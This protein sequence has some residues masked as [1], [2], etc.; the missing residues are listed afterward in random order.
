[1]K[2]LF[3]CP[4]P[5]NHVIVVEAANTEAAVSK[6]LIAGALHCRNVRYQCRCEKAQ[7]QTTPIPEEKL[8]QIVKICLTEV[9]KSVADKDSQPVYSYG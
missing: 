9:H 3:A 6:L 2:Y 1:M 4:A 8:R 5:C 7:S